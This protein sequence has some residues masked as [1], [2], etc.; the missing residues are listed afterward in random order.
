MSSASKNADISR[1]MRETLD[2]HS[3]MDC[4]VFELKIVANKLNRE[5]REY[6]TGIFR[7]AKWIRNALVNDIH[8]LK[9]NFKT[10][11]V[12]AGDTVEE[13]PLRY[14]S[15]QMKQSAVKRVH[16]EIKGLAAHKRKG[17]KVG[18]L[19]FKSFCNSVELKQF[20]VTYDILFDRNRVRIQGIKKPVY[21]RG[22]RQIPEDAEFANARL[23]RKA[24][25][26]YIHVTCF[27]PRKI[28]AYTGHMEGI[29]FGIGHNLTFTDGRV[30]DICVPE[31]K[32]VRLASRRLN[33]SYHRSGNKKSHNHSKRRNALRI[34]YEKDANRRR[35][36]ANQTV[37][38]ILA[39][40]DLVAIQDEMI[41][42]WHAGLFGK[43][44][45]HSAM[46]FIKAKLKT[47]FKVHVV[48]RSFPSTQICPVCGGLTKHPLTKRDYDCAHC[49]YHHDSRDQKSAQ[50]I[51]DKVLFD[52]EVSPEQRAKS[53][54]EVSS[55]APVSLDTVRKNPPVKQEAQVL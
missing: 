38:N 21:V 54:A 51:L 52:L 16:S 50:S 11:P 18:A 47:S 30:E 45:Q 23:L 31:S 40:N 29:D 17:D 8:S 2:R 46:G 42:N 41:H 36:L 27:V 13:R 44:V 43:Q 10:V 35:E 49:G 55:S 24:S 5:Q 32:K 4:L 37:H 12:K 9:P 20:G 15:S 26:L 48:E 39:E 25:G 28:P 53:L 6:I 34:A 1:T 22:L 33:K 7:E 14:I 19:K 3:R